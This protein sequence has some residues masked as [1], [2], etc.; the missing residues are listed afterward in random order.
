MN[1]ADEV[2]HD[3]E[4]AI[5]KI[6]FTAYDPASPEFINAL[7]IGK[8]WRLLTKLDDCC[9]NVEEK[10]TYTKE[11]EPEEEDDEISEK[12]SKSKKYLQKYIDANDELYKTMALDELNHAEVLLKKAYS[13]L[14]N[15]EEKAKLKKYEYE[16]SEISKQINSL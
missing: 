3:F 15:A 8:M 14:P 12:I 7:N 10:E 6:D 13:K 11:T 4:L 5:K 2:K 16:H 9:L 1:V